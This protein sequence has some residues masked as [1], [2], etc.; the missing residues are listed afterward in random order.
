M[1]VHSSHRSTDGVGGVFLL[2]TR[3]YS[4]NA[5]INFSISYFLTQSQTKT[6]KKR[7]TIFIPWDPFY[8]KTFL[9]WFIQELLEFGESLSNYAKRAQTVIRQRH[10][11]MIQFFPSYFE[12]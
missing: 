6:S 12:H 9:T 10:C 2:E 11:K 4:V 5:G 7:E 8:R 1:E 3:F